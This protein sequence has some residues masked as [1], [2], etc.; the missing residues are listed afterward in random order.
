MK[1]SI[2][3]LLPILLTGCGNTTITHTPGDDLII[4]MNEMVQEYGE[5]FIIKY[6]DYEIVVDSGTGAE[7]NI[8]KSNLAKY[9]T[10]NVIDLLVITHPH[11]DHIGGFNNGLF[12]N[13]SIT[14]LVDF[15]YT[16][17]TDG[18]DEISSPYIYNR[19]I[20]ERT[21]LIMN[22]TNYTPI[23]DA[24]KQGK[25][26]ISDEDYLSL[27]WLKNNY[28]FEYGTTFPNSSVS[29]T[30]PNI[31]SVCFNLSYKNWNFLFM[32]DADS[33]YTETSIMKNHQKLYNDKNARVALKATHH[34]SST[35][36][37]TSFLRWSKAES[38]FCSAAMIDDICAPNQ[39]Q[40]GS[41][42]GYQ[43]HPNRSTVKRIK[44]HL[45]SLSSNQFYWNAINGTL[46]ITCDGVNDLTYFG[47]GRSKNYLIK[48]STE[49]ANIELEK[50]ISFFESEFNKYF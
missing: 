36:L 6:G 16:Y 44:N 45:E 48:N 4:V 10:D 23:T 37:G 17:V 42:E 34:A 19:Y 41:K 29:Q 24:L 22:G 2:F 26:K 18:D 11:G 49:E 21:E 30:N 8:I 20:Q 46:K 27:E 39:V 47:D 3:L 15:G 13:Y 7:N 43:N 50:H 12:N 32:G 14:N 28:Y 5:C 31:T 25:V 1:K 35:S 33:T 9:C 38:V 40:L